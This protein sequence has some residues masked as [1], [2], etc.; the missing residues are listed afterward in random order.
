MGTVIGIDIGGS[1]TK[2]VGFRKTEGG[3]PELIAPQFVRAHDPITSI[4]GAFGKFTSENG[5]GLGDID[6]VMMTG[7]GSSFVKQPIYGLDCCVVP[8]FDSVGLGGLY[9]SGL[10]EAIVVSMGTGTALIHAK[11]SGS[12]TS[13]KYLGGTGVGGGTLVGLSKKIIGIDTIEHIEA[14]CEGGDLSKV[15][16]RIGDLSNPEVF[17]ELNSNLT[18][19]NFGNVSDLAG[20]HDLALGIVN[21]VAET[22]AMLAVFAARGLNISDVVLTGNLVTLGPICEAFA[23]LRNTFNVHFTVPQS[24]RFGTVI[25]AAL[26][27]ME[28]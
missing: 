15:N 2:I 16:L 5:L 9:L 20:K 28:K 4:Y 24:A 10:D 19:S 7:V 25:G 12:K 6:R 26:R 21:M 1:T 14:L 18:A 3:A 13:I 22:I 27:G 11:R 8:E 17:P 23:A